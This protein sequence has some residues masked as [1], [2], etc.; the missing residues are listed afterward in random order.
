MRMERVMDAILENAFGSPYCL[1]GYAYLFLD[2]L[3]SSGKE[4][5]EKPINRVKEQ[6]ILQ[7]VSYIEQHY[8][9]DLSMAELADICRLNRGYFSKI[10]KE[11]MDTT[12]QQFLLRFRMSQACSLLKHSNVSVKEIGA[13]VGH[14]DQ[15]HF[16]RAFKSVFSQSPREWRKQNA[17]TP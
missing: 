15:L 10:F 6:Y 5:L 1:V 12:P 14:P 8:M 3:M 11:Q 16:S 17:G 7:A 9:E 2:C 13:A 4:A